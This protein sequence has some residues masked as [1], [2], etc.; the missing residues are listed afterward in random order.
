MTKQA[1]FELL[2]TLGDIDLGALRARMSRDDIFAAWGYYRETVGGK[3]TWNEF[4][5]SVGY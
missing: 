1:A 5:G 2:E 3:L 4:A